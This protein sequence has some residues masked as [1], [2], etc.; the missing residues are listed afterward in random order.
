LRWVNEIFKTHFE[1]I[2]ES[3][4]SQLVVF[5]LLIS[6]IIPPTNIVVPLISKYLLVV[7]ILNILSVFNTCLIISLY[8]TNLKLNQINPWVITVF[9]KVL[10]PILFIRRP[11]LKQTNK[12]SS[13]NFPGRRGLYQATFFSGSCGQMS[14][15]NEEIQNKLCD[16]KE[17]CN[18]LTS[19]QGFVTPSHLYNFNKYKY[20]TDCEGTEDS[21]ARYQN[22]KRVAKSNYVTLANIEV[23]KNI[24]SVSKSIQYISQLMKD[25]AEI[26]S[27]RI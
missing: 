3:N 6:K 27:V 20:T 5:F 12:Q 10:P 21:Y 2:I 24:V 16:F 19:R 17:N 8:F 1:F 14:S 11:K 25:K 23:T 7:F 22:N 13:E 9:F 26:E 15:V 18:I 4:F